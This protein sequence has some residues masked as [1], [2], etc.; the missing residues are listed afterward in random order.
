MKLQI[1]SNY[2]DTKYEDPNWVRR[3]FLFIIL[4]ILIAPLFISVEFNLK[5]LFDDSSIQVTKN[6]LKS[7]FPPEISFDFLMLVF[8]EAL[9]T[10]SIATV[11]LVCALMIGIPAAIIICNS[12]SFSSLEGK[13][14]MTSRFFR[15]FV[16]FFLI[17]LRSVPELVWALLFIR[18]VG[19]GPTAAIIAISLTYGGIIGKVYAEI[20]ESGGG[21]I[22]DKFF[23]NGLS[24][25]Q[26]LFF[27]LIPQNILEI[28]SYTIYRWECAVR[29]TV[30]LGFVGAGGLGQ[31]LE[32][33][34]KM[35]AGGEICTLLIAFIVL[36]WF[37][38]WLSRSIRDQIL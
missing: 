20:L 16:R 32:N 5:N 27:V 11:G 36:V 12:L 35:F 7:F 34:M 38:D 19:L 15:Y 23:L 10:I 30:I 25:F 18:V 17:F 26:I 28:V 37:A 8:N 31:Q 33:S 21:E 2:N 4:I 9:V 14:K 22:S 6:F 29:S 13:T 3:V 1:S 24:R